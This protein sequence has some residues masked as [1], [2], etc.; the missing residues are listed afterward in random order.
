MFTESSH[1][2]YIKTHQFYLTLLTLGRRQRDTW[3]DIRPVNR[4]TRARMDRRLAARREAQSLLRALAR[5]GENRAKTARPTCGRTT[6]SHAASR[7][8][9]SAGEAISWDF[10]VC[11]EIR[12]I[13]GEFERDHFSLFKSLIHISLTEIRWKRPRSKTTSVTTVERWV[14]SEWTTTTNS[15]SALSSQIAC[16]YSTHTPHRCWSVWAKRRRSSCTTTRTMSTTPPRRLAQWRKSVWGCWRKSE[17]LFDRF[18]TDS[19]LIFAKFYRKLI[20]QIEREETQMLVLRVMVGLVIL[21]DHVHPDGAFVKTSHV[22]V[23]GCVKLL[24]AQPAIKAE[25][26]LNALR[27]TTKHLNEEGT[28]KNIK[29]LLAA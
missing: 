26:L 15:W 7:D 9:A 19:W 29:I 4:C 24:Q 1:F 12:R 6:Q 3:S 21:Y 27:Y 8:T 14:A 17:E 28:P 13:Q 18:K 2:F 16:H 20:S 10:G 11:F 23:K 22:D 5:A 25:P